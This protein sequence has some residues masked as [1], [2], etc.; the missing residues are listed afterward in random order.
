MLQDNGQFYSQEE[1]SKIYHIN[2]NHV[3][4]LGIKNCLL[5]HYNFR[6]NNTQIFQYTLKG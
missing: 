1:L 4:Y 6:E 3:L 2:I 5:Q